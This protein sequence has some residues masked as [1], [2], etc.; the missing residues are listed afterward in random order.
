MRILHPGPARHLSVPPPAVHALRPGSAPAPRHTSVAEPRGRV[1]A[2][3]TAL[4]LALALLLGLTGLAPAA[5]GPVSDGWHTGAGIAG[6]G[7]F[8]G[9]HRNAEGV[10]AYCTDFERFSPDKASGYGDGS[11]GPF[12]RSDGSALSSGDNAVLAFVLGRWGATADNDEAAAVQLAVW[13]LTAA[14]MGWESPAMSDFIRA[15]R[16]PPG[17]EAS[18][19][20]MVEQGRAEAGSYSISAS[21]SPEGPGGHVSAA[22][23]SADGA[24]RPG[25][26]VQA[27]VEGGTFQDGSTTAEWTSTADPHVLP[28]ARTGFQAGRVRITASS[29]PAANAAWLA[30]REQDVQRLVVAPVSAEAAASVDLPAPGR[31]A[32]E[33][34]TVTSATRTAPGTAV[35]DVLDVSVAAPGQ[36]LVDPATARPVGL[37]VVSTLWGPLPSAPVEGATVP[38]GTASV[39]TVT[40]A[41]A[42][43]G[44]FRTTALTVPSAGYYAWTESIDPSTARPAAAAPFIAPWAGPYGL[45]L[46]TT[47]VPWQP[48]L[49]TKLSRSSALPGAVVQDTVTAEGFN[50]DDDG[51]TVQLTMY[52]PFVESPVESSAIPVDAPVHSEVSVPA[53]DGST[54][55]GDFA[56]LDEPGCY[57][58][59]AVFEGSTDEEPFTSAFGI[60]EETVCVEAPPVTSPS[61]AFAPAPA[62][63]PAAAPPAPVRPVV[64]APRGGPQLAATG[65]SAGATGGIALM[66]L[67]LGMGLRVAARRRGKR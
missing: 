52:G 17:V 6:T 41:I 46:E 45:P 28:V 1:P 15:R 19:R 43:T 5:A 60:P 61:P 23:V 2:I 38:S 22:V 66:T 65:I 31:F 7:Y 21:F 9:Q 39:G 20:S 55:S 50:P 18:A 40:T 37:D 35:H 4:A 64:A 51:G 29:V 56:P 49:S 57:T 67:G 30:P 24:A 53:T 32:P 14:G 54:I 12:I 47:L 27:V 48:A 62:P 11:T 63:A 34:S 10:I 25:Q 59:V 36:W 3:R 26:K 8:V 33:V 58:V 13:S 44:S 42:G 16:L